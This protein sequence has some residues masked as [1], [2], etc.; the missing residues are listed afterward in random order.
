MTM[1]A[2][3]QTHKKLHLRE[4]T[5]DR[6]SDSQHRIDGLDARVRD[7]YGLHPASF[8][9]DGLPMSSRRSALPRE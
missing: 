3:R 1:T 7:R 9:N 8:P 6:K 2:S 4:L 5:D